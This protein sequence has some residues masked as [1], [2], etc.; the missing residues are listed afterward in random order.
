VIPGPAPSSAARAVWLDV[1]LTALTAGGLCLAIA[2]F[3]EPEAR[4]PDAFAYTYGVLIALPLLFR[5]RA[6]RTVLVV[7]Y[8]LL[9]LYYVTGYPAVGLVLPLVVSLATVAVAGH[10]RFGATVLAVT[11]TW[12]SGYRL[13][14]EGEVVLSVLDDTMRDV[15]L[16]IAALLFGAAVRSERALAAETRARTAL[17]AAER[18]REAA[19]RVQRERVRLARELHDELAHSVTVMGMHAD[20][21]S[22]AIE[23][24]ARDPARDLTGVQEAVAAIRGVAR[25]T[26]AD[27]RRTLGALRGDDGGRVGTSGTAA[28]QHLLDNAEAAGISTGLTVDLAGETLSATLDRTVHR[29]VQEAVT[30]TLRHADATHLDVEVVVAGRELIVGV[31]DDG[32]GRSDD[33][34][35]R[36]DDG[37]GRSDDGHGRSDDGRARS[38][39]AN[40]DGGG[41]GLPGMRERVVLLGGAFDAGPRP[42]GGFAVRARLPLD[43]VSPWAGS[44]S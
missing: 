8:A 10:W 3:R 18:E 31:V 36:S 14:S 24:A 37:H 33:G 2:V 26:M 29:V 13:V 19:A 27:L 21:A 30:N 32:R 9:G 44:T 43:A 5:R 17:L 12:G 25:D 22:E 11:I 28:V 7:N 20:V 16:G 1:F 41:H 4:P 35:G 42:G 39:D 40:G 15:A 6:P 38:D 34:R 23:R